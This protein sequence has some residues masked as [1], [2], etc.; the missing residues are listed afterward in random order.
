MHAVAGAPY[1][2]RQGFWR[3]GERL[4]IGHF[5]HGG[6]AAHDGGAAAAFQVFLVFSARFAEMHLAVD[7]AG[8]NMKTLAIDHLGGAA[9]VE[10]SKPCNAAAGN[11]NVA[12]VGSVMVDNGAALE[13]EIID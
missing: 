6:D 2:V 5:K 9:L 12:L 11:G 1:L 4:R 8:E 3:G 10:Y 7:D 13:N